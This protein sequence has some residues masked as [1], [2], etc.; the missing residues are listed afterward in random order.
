VA[1]FVTVGVPNFQNMI[2][3]NRL[4]TQANSLVSSLHLARSEALKLR[5]PVSICRSTDGSSCAGA[6]VWESG[7]LVF[8]D[9]AN[10]GTVDSGETIIQAVSG[11]SAGNTLRGENSVN[12]YIGF[13][14]TG[15][16]STA[17]A[18]GSFRL[19]SGA[20]PDISKGRQIAI[21]PTGRVSSSIGTASCP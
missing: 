6:G 3:D 16:Q 12:N 17:A 2:G 10:A 8:I 14:P 1:I 5:S 4:S 13:Q 15:L 11:I 21:S 18:G 20:N 9:S 7:W 19:C